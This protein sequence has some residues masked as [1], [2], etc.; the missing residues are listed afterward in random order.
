MR[1]AI[2]EQFKIFSLQIVNRA[3]AAICDNRS[4]FDEVCFQTNGLILPV[5]FSLAFI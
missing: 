2:F 3:P 5:G 1:A 4:N